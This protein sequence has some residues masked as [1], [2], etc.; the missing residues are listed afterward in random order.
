METI[1]MVLMV[2][3]LASGG[4]ASW[5]VDYGLSF[6]DCKSVAMDWDVASPDVKVVCQKQLGSQ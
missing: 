5:V 3:Q 4:D 6:D 2:V 1:Y